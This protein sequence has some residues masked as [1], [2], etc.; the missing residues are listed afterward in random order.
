MVGVTISGLN[1]S[2]M[3][4]FGRFVTVGDK[5]VNGCQDLCFPEVIGKGY[6]GVCAPR[7]DSGVAGTLP[8]TV[9]DDAVDLVESVE[10][11]E[12]G[13]LLASESVWVSI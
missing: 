5:S 4:L 12:V 9:L 13:M 6:D 3:L 8:L 10:E 11:V 7:C 2:E 1:G